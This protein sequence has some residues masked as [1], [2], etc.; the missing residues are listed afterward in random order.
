MNKDIKKLIATLLHQCTHHGY[1]MEIIKKAVYK[2][3]ELHHEQ[4]RKS[5]E[6]Y[7]IHPLSV[8]IEVAELDLGT[9]AVCAAL[10]HDTIEDCGVN[11]NFIEENFNPTVAKLVEGVTK[12]DA[13]AHNSNKRFTEL[14]NVRKLIISSS[15][16]IRVLLIKL[17]DRLHNM[18]TINALSI[19]KQ[20]VYADETLKVYVPLAEYIGIGKWKRELEDIAF[21]KKESYFYNEIKKKIE[22]D[23]RVH[24]HMLET[25]LKDIEK[26]LVEHQV[27]P[28]KTYGRIK[29]IHSTFNKIY[30]KVLDGKFSSIEEADISE[31]KDLVAISVVLDTDEIECYK[32]LGLVHAHF[33]Y[34]PKD[35]ADYIAKPKANGYRALHTV[36]KYKESVAEIQIKTAAMHEV[37]EFGPASHI[38]YKLS[39]KKQA[40]ASTQYGWIKNLNL[41]VDKNADDAKFKVEAFKDQ[42]FAIT[43]KGRVIELKKGATTIDFAYMVHTQVGNRFIGAKVNDSIAKADT[44]LRNGDVVEILTS[45]TPKKPSLEWVKFAKLNSTKQK[46][47]HELTVQEKEAS[48]QKGKVDLTEYI[49]KSIKID[50]LTLD[51]SILRFLCGEF[52]ASDID[53]FYLGVYYGNI[54]KKEVL[55]RLIKKLNISTPDFEQNVAIEKTETEPAKHTRSQISIEG[56]S[57]LDYKLAGCCK[58][59]RGDDIVGLVTLRDGLKIHRKVCPQLDVIEEARK[60]NAKWNREK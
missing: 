38:A 59:I 10:L 34:V 29:S 21:R 4:R 27:K 53:T 52:G 49:L 12:I 16:D 5:G 32:V 43:P 19:E 40:Q 15:E 44:L 46:I 47:R 18:R 57:D 3:E 50:W 6:P 26:I 9:D 41:W 8:A 28:E 36:V 7:Y 25:L 37:N 13:L 20:V 17:A 56:D 14:L 55:K 45:K 33:E 11:K 48:L 54:P 35:F 22:N 42:I 39:G 1:D 24:H 30:K 31:L 23:P 60:L 2:G 51:S 58:P